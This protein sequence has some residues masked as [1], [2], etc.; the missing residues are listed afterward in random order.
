ML[1]GSLFFCLLLVSS[2]S[3]SQEIQ[4]RTTDQKIVIDGLLNDQAWSTADSADHFMQ[5]F[6][7]DT[8][9]ANSQTVAKILYDD[10][11]VYISGKMYNLEKDRSYFTPSLRRDFFGDAV[12]SF[13]VI[14]DTFQDETNGFIFGIN[15]YGVRREGLLTNGGTGR[16]G[17]SLDWDNKWY[18]EA[19]RH[20][21]GYWTAEMAI[22]LKTL[23][24]NE[25]QSQ[26][27]IN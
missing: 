14:F 5:Q 24:F 19:V 16:E 1:R 3:W 15:P 7:A 25:G 20:P 13:S 12:D 17:F 23:R 8:S 6:P 11:F 2:L 21:E 26:W 10:Q 27:N 22:P 4:I 18:G 9:L